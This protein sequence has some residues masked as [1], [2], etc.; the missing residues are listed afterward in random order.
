MVRLPENT[1]LRVSLQL[2]NSPPPEVLRFDL[3]SDCIVF[4]G[5]SYLV[6]Y[7]FTVVWLF[8]SVS[9]LL[10]Q[11][12]IDVRIGYLEIS[13][14][15]PPIL[16]NLDKIPE[17][18]GLAGANLAIADNNTT[19]KF[20]GQTYQLET[21]LLDETSNG[22]SEAANLLA[23]SPYL[24]VSASASQLTAI[25]NLPEAKDA[26][27]F[28]VAS[29]D[30]AL[31]DAAC[32][33]NTFHTIPSRSMLADAVSQFAVK[34]R[35]KNWVLIEGAAADDKA[36]AAAI[37][38]S[39]VKFGLNMSAKKEWR[40]DADMR[41]NA[42]QEVPLFTQDFPDH[43]LIVIAD[44]AN[45]FARYVMYNTWLPRPVAG[46]EGIKASAWSA[47]VEQHGAAQLQSR[48]SD[49]AARDMRPTD[50]AA[51][52]AVRSLGE[53]V[54]RTN[55][56]EASILRK[57][58][59]SEKFQL[60]GFKGRPLTFRNWNGQLRQPIPLTHPGAVIAMAPMEGFLHQ[61]NELDTLGVDRPESNCTTFGGN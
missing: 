15:R 58:M 27:I 23:Q 2:S 21:V 30:N 16:S 26:I 39:A 28:N 5:V 55:S 50:Y 56:G 12:K 35:W 7:I 59:L 8:A 37:E 51:W 31:R 52:A 25:S 45:D 33:A 53:A 49:L 44:E 9:T 61:F 20:L 29:R 43:D 32:L 1:G 11:Q 4:G 38:N 22:L 60:A 19:G 40:F 41:R 46:S 54:I 42:A 34:K 36:F 47:S 17:D 3:S 57:Y 6:R 10:A 48:F 24:L 13:Q 14:P 18:L